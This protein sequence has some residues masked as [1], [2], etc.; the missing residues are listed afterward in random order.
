MHYFLTLFLIRLF[1]DKTQNKKNS[2]LIF[3]THNIAFLDMNLFRKDQI[4]LI[5]KDPE[6]GASDLYSLADFNEKEPKNIQSRY[7]LGKYGAVPLIKE[8]LF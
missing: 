7:L 8:E 5:D 4:W 1:H 3:T 6:T 2:Q